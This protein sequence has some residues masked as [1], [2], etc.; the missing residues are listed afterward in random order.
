MNQIQILRLKNGEDIIGNVQEYA[1]GNFGIS[2]PMQVHM[3]FRGNS[4]NL[5]MAH[6]LPVQLIKDNQTNINNAEVLAKFEPNQ[7]FAEYYVN[8][9]QKI[10]DA[11]KAK[12]LANTMNDDEIMEVMNA[13]E[14]ISNQTIH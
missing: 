12:Q 3:E 8:T 9:V 1:N 13:L 14:D 7:D 5:V 11:L 10:Q 4:Q 2:E 6:W